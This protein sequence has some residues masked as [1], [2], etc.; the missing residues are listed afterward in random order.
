[1]LFDV[2]ETFTRALG[3][4]RA[5]RFAEAEGLYRNVLSVEPKHGQS[6][7]LL[8][9]VLLAQ[10]KP[11]EALE[12][13][14][15]ALQ[16]EETDE[17]RGLFVQCIRD[18][19]PR[20]RRDDIR[21]LLAR[22]L[23]DAWTRPADL[24]RVSTAYVKLE[25]AV[26][27]GIARAGKAWPQ[28]LAAQDIP[29]VALA[30]IFED[31]LLRALLET[32]PICDVELEWLLGSLRSIV[33]EI[34]TGKRV[35]GVTDEV[36]LGFACALARQCFLNDYVYAA[37]DAELARAE[38]LRE[39]L[40]RALR[41]GETIPPLWVAAVAAYFPLHEV[42]GAEQ[43]TQKSWHKAVSAVLTQQVSEPLEERQYR[44]GIPRLTAIDDRVSLL[45][46]QHYEENPY[47]HWQKTAAPA[48]V[49]LDRILRD[50]FPRG[51][52]R[53]PEKKDAVDVL[54]AGCG[55][56]QHS[57]ET[58]QQIVGARVLAID[59]S[60]NSLA[61]AVRKTR[62]AGVK[63][64]EYA[65]ADVLQLQALGR[66][67]DLIEA[68]GVLHHLEDPL[69]G[70]RILL[71]LLRP[72]G[73]MRLGLYSETARA[74]VIAVRALIAARGYRASD[75]HRCREEL[76]DLE[77]D[78][79]AQKVTQRA[80]FFTTRA[81][82]DLLFHVHELPLTLPQIEEFLRRHELTFLGFDVEPRI[83]TRYRARFPDDAA[84][85]NLAQWHLLETE[86]PTTFAGMYQFWVQK[87]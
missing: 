54:I 43:L 58:A 59:L 74:D 37:D 47:P 86:H 69:E 22:A 10:R 50:R 66:T 27:D 63:N 26:R 75:V 36:S 61:Y 64:I 52:Y 20:R 33:Q 70:W 28:R 35:P 23:S 72:S 85:T 39:E 12:P 80:D 6:L 40:A 38:R 51:G 4:H 87:P 79:A 57:I 68:G 76:M 78:P 56:G 25:P 14:T 17:A 42:A 82:R 77:N 32:T 84:M 1:M 34:A 83:L 46:Q 55:T 48:P 65:Q 30:P 7:R 71:T 21:A 60:L 67:F 2:H 44:D 53:A 41:A 73:L 31:Q 15:R 5:G 11:A 8:A 24:A 62:A 13:V 16:A 19:Q 3:S 81:C 18:L 29:T 49:T 9:T 45:V